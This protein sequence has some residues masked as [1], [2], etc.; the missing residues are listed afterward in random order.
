MIA[1]H[2]NWGRWGEEDQLGTLNLIS[3]EAVVRGARSVLSGVRVSCGRVLSPTLRP[4]NPSPVLHHMTV[5]GESA[6]SEGLGSSSDWIGLEF[7][8]FATSHLDAPSHLFFDGQMYNGRPASLVKTASGAHA[9]SVELAMNGI[10]SRGVLL[11]V[12]LVLDEPWLEPGWSITAE[13]LEQ[14]E[15]RLGV[16]VEPGDVLLV[17][18]GRDARLRTGGPNVS[19]DD[20][21]AGLD[22]DCVPWLAD[23][24]VAA[25]G[26]DGANDVFLPSG[27]ESPLPVHAAGIVGL[28]LWL[29]DNLYLD[30]LAEACAKADRWTFQFT[31]G[32]LRIKRGTGSPVNPIA[33]L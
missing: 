18:T 29:F 4:D 32:P 30:D 17:R 24:D 15:Q 3:D 31:A 22:G 6:A 11:D 19:I 28:G 23:R 14:C 26:G 27:H 5:S 16:R 13:V 9:G 25:L 2:G 10:V 20:G 21:F 8:G 33:V 1:A 12:P 7:H